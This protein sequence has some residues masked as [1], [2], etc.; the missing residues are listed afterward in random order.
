[1]RNDRFG[2]ANRSATGQPK[3]GVGGAEMT[4]AKPPFAA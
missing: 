4:D 2:E 1:M 3:A